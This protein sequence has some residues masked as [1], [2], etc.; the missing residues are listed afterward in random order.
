[1]TPFDIFNNKTQ[2]TKNKA[3]TIL[4]SG[5]CGT[6]M[7]SRSI[8]L[9]GVDL[10][11]DLL[12]PDKTNPKG[13]WENKRIVVTHKEIINTL[14]SIPFRKGWQ[15]LSKIKPLK[16]KMKDTVEEQFFDK[17]LWGWKD[18]RTSECIEMWKEI[19]SDMD[20][21][22]NYLIMIR[23]PLDVAASFR[24]AYDRNEKVALKQWQIRTLLALRG[25]KKESRIIVDYDDFIED[26]FGTVKNIAKSFGVTLPTDKTW[27]KQEL[28]SFIDPTLRHSRTGLKK[29]SKSNEIEKDMKELYKVCHWAAHSKKYLNSTKFQK[30]IDS[31]YQSFLRNHF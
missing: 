31:L 29:L 23:N 12:K 13:F 26:S 6:S 1:M 22:G 18:P 8:N 7:A 24:R 14:G 2:K 10:G 16:K 30:K 28:N 11:E 20:V 9:M 3:I 27:L 15:N 17:P 25:T 19:L 4:G 21:K 5:R